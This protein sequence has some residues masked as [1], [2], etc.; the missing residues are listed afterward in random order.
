M[1]PILLLSL[2]LLSS[3]CGAAA[4]DAPR[5]PLSELGARGAELARAPFWLVLEPGDTLP[6][7]LA[8][9]GPLVDSEPGATAVLRVKRR[10]FVLVGDG[11]PKISLDG[12]TFHGGGS[13]TVGLGV[14]EDDPAPRGTV[15]V[16]IGAPR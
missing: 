7:D 11:P 2:A 13:L 1:R 8:V 12:V 6:I 9:D 15:R 5:V 16:T 3:A 4:A 10:F 14:S